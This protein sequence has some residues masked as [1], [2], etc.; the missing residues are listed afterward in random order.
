MFELSVITTDK[1]YCEIKYKSSMENAD[2][3]FEASLSEI[4]T[5]VNGK[6]EEEILSR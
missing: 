6:E 5:F 2:F 4:L 1:N 3:M